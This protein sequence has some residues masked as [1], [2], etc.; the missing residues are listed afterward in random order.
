VHLDDGTER[1]VD[2]LVLGTGYRVDI[3][4]YSF[5][6]RNLVSGIR[7]AGGFPVLNSN[8]EASAPGLYFV[9]APSAWSYGPLMFFVAGADFA[10][11]VVTRHIAKAGR[12]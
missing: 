9:G 6:S 8:L 12:S 10:A 11:R 5:L 4:R 1:V 2:H 3:S 7:Q